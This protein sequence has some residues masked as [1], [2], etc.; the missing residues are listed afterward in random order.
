MSRLT[1]AL[2]WSGSDVTLILF[3]AF[4]GRTTQLVQTPDQIPAARLIRG[5]RRAYSSYTVVTC[6][7]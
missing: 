1:D 6:L 2:A 5:L 3:A 7:C 4:P